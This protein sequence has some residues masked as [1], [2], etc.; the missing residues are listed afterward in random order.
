MLDLTLKKPTKSYLEEN[1]S[2]E[3]YLKRKIERYGVDSDM[4]SLPSKEYFSWECLISPE[5]DYYPCAFGNHLGSAYN[6]IKQNKDRFKMSDQLIHI[7]ENT[8]RE[9]KDW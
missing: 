3:E 1:L 9:I 4:I 7:F 2:D 6:I 8:E 5:G